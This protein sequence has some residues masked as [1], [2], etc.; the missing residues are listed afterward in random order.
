MCVDASPPPSPSR[1][2]TAAGGLSPGSTGTNSCLSLFSRDTTLGKSS[3]DPGHKASGTSIGKASALAVYR[4]I[5]QKIDLARILTSQNSKHIILYR[6][7]Q[8]I[9]T[10]KLFLVYRPP[11][12]ARPAARVWPGPAAAGAARRG[13]TKGQSRG[14]YGG[15]KEWRS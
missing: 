1:E 15:P 2:G 14:S 5:S 7:I 13:G 3:T 12:H 4:T 8:T 11:G 6:K 10:N 9:Q